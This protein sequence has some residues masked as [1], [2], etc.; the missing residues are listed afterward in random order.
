MAISPDGRTLVFSGTAAGQQQVYA[1]ALDELSRET[2]LRTLTTSQGAKS[3]LQWS[4]DSRE[5]W[6]LEGGR[7]AAVNAES[8]VVRTVAASAEVDVN[9]AAEKQA[10]FRQSWNFLSRNFFDERMNGVDW[11]ALATTVEPYVEG[12][13]TP[14]DLRRVLSLMIGELNASH[15]GISGATPGAV[16]IPVA[17]LGVRFDRAA[18]DRDGS[19]V[20]R[21]V[22]LQGPAAVGNVRV[23]DRLVAIDGT[24]VRAGLSVDSLLMGKVGRRV[25]LSVAPAAGSASGS[26]SGSATRDVILRPVTLA[27]EKA[28]AYRQWVEERRAYVATASG[29]RL[30]YVHMFDM[31]QPSLDQL[32]LDLDAE[33][34]ARDGVV[35]DVRNNNGGFVN[36]YAI[37]VLSRRSYLNFTDRNSGTVTPARNSLGQRMLDR[38]TVLVTNQHTLSD[39][40][41]F[42]EGYRAL[43]LGKVVGEPTAGW[44]I[45]TSNVTLL[46]GAS[47]LRLPGTRV[48]DTKGKDMEMHP[49][50]VDI[51]AVRP[52]GES[53]TGK[54]SQLDAA[55]QAL[56]QSLP[57]RP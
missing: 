7:I 3:D 31:G 26:A 54:D 27:A 37:D 35:V 28:L 52:I 50:P 8:R 47:S 40:E 11:P 30:G 45:F 22:I 38:P 14:D 18:L 55:V 53:Y 9:F 33:N 29:G 10:I 2:A 13:R 49:R 39:G 48:T 15:L 51:A 6:Y 4:P 56:L 57:K 17:R 46:D 16:S 1:W 19:L 42:T 12:S 23:G 20:V 25:T 32:Y 44:I 21:E 24:P 36:V 34:Q 41:D 43:G 5:L